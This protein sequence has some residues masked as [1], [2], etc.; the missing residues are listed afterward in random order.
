MRLIFLLSLSTMCFACVT[1]CKTLASASVAPT[2][3]TNPLAKPDV[4]PLSYVGITP[5]VVDDHHVVLRTDGTRVVQR[6]WAE[7]A[8]QLEPKDAT[9][10]V[11]ILAS[12][13]DVVPA[14]EPQ[15]GDF[16]VRLRRGDKMITGVFIMLGADANGEGAAVKFRERQYSLK[17]EYAVALRRLIASISCPISWEPS[18]ITTL[19]EVRAPAKGEVPLSAEV[20]PSVE[21]E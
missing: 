19:D 20:S 16:V 13:E 5:V 17:S 1:A 14:R 12:T 7:C 21:P 11:E 15:L 6:G 4:H 9:T 3:R 8:L 18:L 10:L 2:E